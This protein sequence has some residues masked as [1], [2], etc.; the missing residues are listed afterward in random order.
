MEKSYLIKV[1]VYTTDSFEIH[2]DNVFWVTYQSM[3]DDVK[4]II[5]NSFKCIVSNNRNKTK[6][7]VLADVKYYDYTIGDRPC[8]LV[9]MAAY[10][11]NINDGY[12]EDEEKH[13][14]GKEGKIGSD[15]NYVLLYPMINGDDPKT[16]QC[17]FILL[18]YEDPTK[19]SGAVSRLARLLVSKVLKHPIQNIKTDMVL[20]ELKTI[21]TIPEL[22]IKYS[23]VSFD[24]DDINI[25]YRE[26][27]SESKLERARESTFKNMPF[28][29]IEDL[30]NEQL[31]TSL[32][33]K[34]KLNFIWGKK[35][36]HITKQMIGE[37]QQEFQE[38][39]EQV[40]NASTA[41]TQSELDNKVHDHAFII[42]KLSAVLTNYLSNGE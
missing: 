39:A 25:K 1:P 3:I 26:Y 35:E 40:F 5:D 2:E 36:Y 28:H 30:V 41:I 29:V 9:Q 23:G 10:S 18:V 37:A 11:T 27:L 24:E 38:T 13:A 12:F 42:E 20:R 31:D 4:A 16:Q 22:Q 19:D 6:M 33:Q 17:F 14:I 7:S 15:S 8:L 21:G 34:Q 32:Y